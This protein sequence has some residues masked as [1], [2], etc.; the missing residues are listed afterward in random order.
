M[1]YQ[2]LSKSLSWQSQV[3]EFT[4]IILNY[5]DMLH[6]VAQLLRSA[7]HFEGAIQALGTLLNNIYYE[8]LIVLMTRGYTAP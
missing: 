1:V 4:E 3:L 7:V 2:R 5:S 8:L 6:N